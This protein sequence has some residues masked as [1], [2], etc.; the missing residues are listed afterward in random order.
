MDATVAEMRA[1]RRAQRGDDLTID[2]GDSNA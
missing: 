1:W 2:Q